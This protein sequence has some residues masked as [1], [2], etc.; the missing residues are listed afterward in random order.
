MQSL[1]LYLKSFNLFVVM[2]L[3]FVDHQTFESKF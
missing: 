3:T 1:I 2:K